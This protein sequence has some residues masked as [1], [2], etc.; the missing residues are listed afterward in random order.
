MVFTTG[1]SYSKIMY[2]TITFVLLN[3]KES[4][5]FT[6]VGRLSNPK[7]QQIDSFC[8]YTFEGLLK[9]RSSNKIFPEISNF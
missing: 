9:N 7:Y 1:H 3:I 8:V 2:L 6:L 5:L 4:L